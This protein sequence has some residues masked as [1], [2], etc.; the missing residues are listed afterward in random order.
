MKAWHRYDLSLLIILLSLFFFPTFLAL[1]VIPGHAWRERF[2]P[3]SKVDGQPLL[4]FELV[5]EKLMIETD[6]KPVAKVGIR[7]EPASSESMDA[8]IEGI[9]H[10]D[11]A[12]SIASS[13]SIRKVG[14]FVYM[15]VDPL[16]RGK[17]LG[18]ELL[19]RARDKCL[20]MGCE[21]MLIVHDDQGSGKLVEYYKQCGFVPIFD[22]LDKGMLCDLQKLQLEEPASFTM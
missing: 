4:H 6:I 7:P 14:I 1:V 11:A 10:A 17:H 21:Y 15:W 20:C 5:S 16:Y 19:R 3:R 2:E 12:T 13:S 18:L 9:F 22:Y 8:L